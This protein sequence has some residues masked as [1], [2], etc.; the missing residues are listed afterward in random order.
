M[1]WARVNS[2]RFQ[3]V[4]PVSTSS[5]MLAM[6]APATMKPKAMSS[7]PAATNGIM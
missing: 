7:P 2:P 3:M 1:Y 5:A 4:E 6:S